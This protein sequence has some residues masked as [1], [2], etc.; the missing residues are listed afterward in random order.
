MQ[1]QLDLVDYP[2]LCDGSEIIAS[3]ELGSYKQLV[4][5]G[6]DKP[7][8]LN[9]GSDQKSVR[10]TLSLTI[11][12]PSLAFSACGWFYKYSTQLF[13]GGTWSKRWIVLAD[14]KLTCFRDCMSSSSEIECLSCSDVTELT[15]ETI[16]GIEEVYLKRGKD[17]S[18]WRIKFM[19]DESILIRRMWIRKLHYN[20]RLF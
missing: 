7:L 18:V 15:S 11:R 19:D 8:S 6:D 1:A 14:K 9:L 3:L 5:G 13:G 16:D 10:Y 17:G 12:Q 20:I 4:Y 2:Q